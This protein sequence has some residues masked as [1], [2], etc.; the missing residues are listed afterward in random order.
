MLPTIRTLYPAGFVFTFFR[1]RHILI[2]RQRVFGPPKVG[3]NVLSVDG[4][5]LIRSK[6]RC[7]RS[8]LCDLDKAL[9]RDHFK[10]PF[11]F[12]GA[13]GDYSSPKAIP[14][15]LHLRKIVGCDTPKAFA[16]LRLLPYILIASSINAFSVRFT[17]SSN[18]TISLGI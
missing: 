8:D 6:K 3:E 10:I 13:V 12:D 1:L 17:A 16:T 4:A 11:H 15:F 18:F 5:G 7:D 14:N 9:L 2:F